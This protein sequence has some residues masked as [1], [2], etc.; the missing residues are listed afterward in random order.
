[1]VI[2]AYWRIA[3]SSVVNALAAER[4]FSILFKLILYKSNFNQKG[5]TSNDRSSKPCCF[6]ISLNLYSADRI[7]R[8]FFT[9]SLSFNYTTLVIVDLFII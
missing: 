7:L 1:M 3:Y 6:R 5:T 9:K 4:K 8:L 2:E